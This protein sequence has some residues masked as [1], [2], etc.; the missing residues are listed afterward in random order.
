MIRNF[1]ISSLRFFQKHRAFTF[2]NILGLGT[3]MAAC[4]LILQYVSYE[5]SYDHYNEK[6]DRIY[7]V[8]YD[9]IRNGEVQFECAA[10]TP[11]VGPAMKRDF[12][13]IEEFARLFP[14]SAIFEYEGTSY[15]EQ[16]V[17][18]A[19]PATFRIF[20]LDIILGDKVD[21]INEPFTMAISTSIA[22]KYFGDDDPIGK[23]IRVDGEE[24]YKI[25]AVFKDLPESSHIKIDALGSYATFSTY[26]W[27]EGMEE[28]WGWYDFNT[29]V[30]VKPG[31]DIDALQAKIP[32]FI[33]RHRGERLRKNNSE[34][35]Y[36]YQPLE[37]IHLYSNLLQESEPPGD[38]QAVYF[39]TIISVCILIIAWVNFVNLSTAR[40]LER[41]KEV[42]IRKVVGA[43]KF[44]LFAQFLSEAFLVNLFSLIFASLIVVL[45]AGYFPQLTGKPI[46]FSTFFNSSYFLW[47]ILI[48]FLGT[49]L[50]GLYPGFVLSNFQPVTVLKGNFGSHSRGASV[51][52]GLVI[53]QFAASVVLIVGTFLVQQQIGFMKAFDVGFEMDQTVILNGA[54]ISSADSTYK[55]K[56]EGFQKRIAEIS[57]VQGLTSS[58]S[59]PGREIFWTRAYEWE[60]SDTEGGFITYIMAIDHHFIPQYEMNLITGRNFS[61]EFGTEESSVIINQAALGRFGFPDA[62]TAIGEKLVGGDTEFKIVGVLDTYHQMGLD[63]DLYPILIRYVPNENSFYSIRLQNADVPEALAKI[64]AE[65]RKVF[66]DDPFSFFFLDEYFNG[67]YVSYIQFGK[68]FGLFSFLGIIIACLGIYGLSSYSTLQRTKEIG[69]RKVLGASSFQIFRLLS[70]DFLLLIIFG[71]FIAWPLA[72]FIMSNWLDSFPVRIDIGFG[73]FVFAGLIGLMIALFTVSIESIKAGLSNPIHSL[74]SE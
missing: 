59:V 6:I 52:K 22:K 45:S 54:E 69:I 12:P 58:S 3:G 60:K 34:V 44:Q 70:W 9:F 13:E 26:E 62:Q 4:L 8:R 28:S 73:L 21:P 43:F 35:R 15:Q 61:P 51:R 50:S 7:R 20:S 39:L 63:K 29:Y 10:A 17:H 2:L 18:I 5:K 53:L 40:S 74:K 55:T 46:D 48:F 24:L 16:K 56:Y 25:T 68:V 30:L 49:F 36:I 47:F 67:Q 65:Y 42:G 72:Y 1:L 31:T 32:E 38:G 71:N 27:S 11:A 23:M 37:D 19:D 33:E 41:A 64:E 57:G 14:T 66:P